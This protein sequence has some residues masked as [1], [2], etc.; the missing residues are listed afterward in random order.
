MYCIVKNLY[1]VSLPTYILYLCATASQDP[2]GV[3]AI[4]IRCYQSKF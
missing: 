2:V 4:Y 3:G 1:K